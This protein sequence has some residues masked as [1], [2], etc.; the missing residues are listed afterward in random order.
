MLIPDR[1][2]ENSRQRLNFDPQQIR[3]AIA[4]KRPIE[5]NP[6]ERLSGW[7][8]SAASERVR[9]EGVSLER[10]INGNDLM[11]VNY[12]ERGVKAARA[13][14]RISL[15]DAG[16][17]VVGYGTGFM[18]SPR[19]LLTNNHVLPKAEIAAQ[20]F[21]RFNY[22][23]DGNGN[24]PPTEDFDF[25]PLTCF[26]TSEELDFS[27]VAV[28]DRSENN[29]PL[30]T[31]GYLLLNATQGKTLDAQFLTIIQHPSGE[32]KQIAIRENQLLKTLD[33]F[34]WYVTDTAP[35][36]SGSCVFND[37]WQVVALHHS[38]VPATDHQGRWLSNDGKIWDPSM[39]DDKVKWVANE[40]VRISSIIEELRKSKSIDAVK[41]MLQAVGGGTAKPPETT[42]VLPSYGPK[43]AAARRVVPLVASAAEKVSI[44]PNY[45]NR[46]CYDPAFLGTGNKRVPMPK[47]SSDMMKSAAVKIDDDGHP[48]HVLTYHHYS[49]VMNRIRR[50]A[51]FTAVNIDGNVSY[52]LKRE[53]DA[54]IFDPRIPEQQQAGEDLYVDND[55]DR[56]HLVRR[57][58]P[59]WGDSRQIAKVANDDTFHFTNC[60]PQH[61]DFNQG[62]NLWAGLEDYILNNADNEDIKVS[63]FTG[64]IFHDGDP[65][66]RGMRIPEEFWKVVVMPKSGGLSATGYLVSQ[67]KL[68]A[69]IV[70][71]EFAFGK[72]KTFQVPVSRIVKL[73]GMEFGKLLDADPLGKTS[74][75]EFVS[76]VEAVPLR[77][78]SQ[79]VV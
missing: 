5:V 52:R 67:A 31:Y 37:A 2:L 1:V 59:A 36:S 42:L 19:L 72:F 25:D 39:G 73:T 60:S 43:T 61:K 68:V 33:H 40:G 41:E 63:V 13:V 76:A 14:G 79:V 57:L 29:V 49:L 30:S 46:H 47:L 32:R 34:L 75:D 35:G 45:D 71:E 58:D 23:L 69:D 77:D 50:L 74:P 24:K 4:G 27:L 70:E 8:V 78:Y 9:A 38:G 21:L 44:D 12:L 16:G 3:A 22:Q 6:P 26:V 10:I 20:S 55:F 51:W 15:G 11:P 62:K 53:K 64:P 18:V 54:W 17:N 48:P 66:Y 7:L 56:G 28:K 65:E